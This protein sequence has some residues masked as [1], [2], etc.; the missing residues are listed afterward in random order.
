M[1]KNIKIILIVVIGIISFIFYAPFLNEKTLEYG[2]FENNLTV[3]SSQ[4]IFEEP[5]IPNTFRKV[6]SPF[7]FK[8]HNLYLS[9]N[10]KS[11]RSC[12]LA[13]PIQLTYGTDGEIR[14]LT[15]NEKNF[16]RRIRFD[17][18][19]NIV[20]SNFSY[21]FTDIDDFIKQNNIKIPGGYIVSSIRT[22]FTVGDEVDYSL[23]GRLTWIDAFGNMFIFFVFWVGVILIFKELGN[24]IRNEKVKD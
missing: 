4:G 24:W 2:K 19:Y 13:Y 18:P 14:N 5:T 6:T 1:D 12:Y 23:I 21:N 3:L 22:N 10:L 9:F 16:I 17:E 11:D 8:Y 7:N 20:L 15:L